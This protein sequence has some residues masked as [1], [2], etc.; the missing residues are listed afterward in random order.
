MEITILTVKSHYFN[1]H[2]QQLCW[3]TRG[4]D[5]L[6]EIYDDLSGATCVPTPGHAG[7]RRSLPGAVPLVLERRCHCCTIFYPD[8]PCRPYFHTSHVAM[9]WAISGWSGRSGIVSLRFSRCFSP[10]PA[11]GALEFQSFPRFAG[12][13][14]HGQDGGLC[15]GLPA[16]FRDLQERRDAH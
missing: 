10:V 15:A 8:N 13:I 7:N 9:S 3:I 4:Y 16:E 11:V 14:R 2:C 1:S 5:D 6:S 12:E